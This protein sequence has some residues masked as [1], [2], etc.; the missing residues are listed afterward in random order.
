LAEARHN[1]G[2][3]TEMVG[4]G[5]FQWA[6]GEWT[7]N[8]AMTLCVARGVLRAPDDPI[9]AIGEEFLR[10]SEQARD[11]GATV[12]A[13]IAVVRAGTPWSL[14]AR[15]T[16]Q[17]LAGLAAGN[18]SLIRTLPLALGYRDRATMLPIAAQVS[19][20][21]H[22]DTQAEMCCAIYSLWVAGIMEGV[23][24]ADA[25]RFALSLGRDWA[26]DSAHAAGGAPA[27]PLPK[28]FWQ[29]LEATPSLPYD[30]LQPSGY[31][32]YVVEALEA[33]SWCC[34]NA[35]SL[36]ESLVLASNLGGDASTIGALTGGVAGAYYGE[37]SVPRRWLAHLQR[38]DELHSLAEGLAALRGL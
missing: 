11:V 20:M 1:H 8:T 19:A 10:W 3:L 36:E 21:T 24:M 22:W 31:A 7:D 5:R 25:W 12:A 37:E 9:D 34:L 17:A 30:R 33:A 28:D 23:V 2:W 32:G 16:P 13:A 35:R 18:G 4:G 27:A 14:A 29:R 6:P 38:Y 15:K 26:R